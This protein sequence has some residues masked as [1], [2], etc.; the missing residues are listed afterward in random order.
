MSDPVDERDRA[1]RV[2]RAG[3]AVRDNGL[4]GGRL[5]MAPSSELSPERIRRGLEEA[6]R[7][8]AEF[9]RAML[10][11][12][13]EQR[14]RSMLE[15]RTPLFIAAR[16]GAL[17]VY[18]R[19]VGKLRDFIAPISPAADM[20]MGTVETLHTA[21]TGT[22]LQYDLDAEPVEV[23]TFERFLAG[24]DIALQVIPQAAQ[25]V[26]AGSRAIRLLA[27]EVRVSVAEANE[28][29]QVLQG[30]GSRHSAMAEAVG[31]LRRS[32]R[33]TTQQF[34][35]LREFE[36]AWRRRRLRSTPA[37]S[38]EQTVR[39]LRSHDAA[40]AQRGIVMPRKHR[41]PPPQREAGS[42]AR[43]ATAPRPAQPAARSQLQIPR[44][45]PM[46]QG[47]APDVGPL[48]G[49]NVGPLPP[50]I[51]TGETARTGGIVRIRAG[52]LLDEGRAFVCRIEGWI[53]RRPGGG[54]LRNFNRSDPGLRAPSQLTVEGRSLHNY[55]YSH[56]F[57]PRWGD[58]ARDG[59]ML[60]P[61]L[62]NQEWLNRNLEKFIDD[63]AGA[64][65]RY[66]GRIFVVATAKS[67]PRARMRGLRG[68]EFLLREVQYEIQVHI[69]SEN[70]GL[71]TVLRASVEIDHP[72]AGGRVH[73]PVIQRASA[74][75]RLFG[76]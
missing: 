17:Q 40:M 31:A 46:G 2:L 51:L 53:F 49:I 54:R 32:K 9:E 16:L 63:I 24:L 19:L 27:R 39:A 73:T 4:A 69:P 44:P 45:V 70:S 71:E 72:V 18:V 57:G 33:L 50:R 1:T 38:L 37:Q 34:R 14:V 56:L 68:R 26:R 6:R 59:L 43:P 25:F 10:R 28:M 22:R 36:Q 60:A 29:V 75:H 74:Y 13:N 76:H 66:G 65:Q 23:S 12:L 42:S 15:L 5:G 67:F 11:A 21:T 3:T 47:S 8:E 7:E 48:R 64:A 30:F 62:F 35:L 52:E 58:E 41:L 61:E 20:V 55:H